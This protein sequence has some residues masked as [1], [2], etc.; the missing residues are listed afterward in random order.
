[1]ILLGYMVTGSSQQSA[2]DTERLPRTT[3]EKVNSY[4]HSI[5][6]HCRSLILPILTYLVPHS[7]DEPN[8]VPTAKF[9][10]GGFARLDIGSLQQ[11]SEFNSLHTY[12]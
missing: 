3:D 1:M 12:S 10:V 11:V 7:S 8:S 9:P 4:T 5:V 2:A 6:R